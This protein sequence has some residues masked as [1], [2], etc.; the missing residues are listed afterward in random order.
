MTIAGCQ[1]HYAIRTD[2]VFKYAPTVEIKHEG[3]LVEVKS[4]KKTIYIAD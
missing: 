1:I 2:N 3:K 4:N